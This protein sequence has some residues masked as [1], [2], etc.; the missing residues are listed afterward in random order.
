[1]TSLQ[2]EFINF[3]CR[4]YESTTI[5][6]RCS[7][8][9][10]KLEQ[11][12][13]VKTLLLSLFL[14]VPCTVIGQDRIADDIS[15]NRDVRPILSDK[16]FQCHG[17]DE[18]SRE[19]DLRFDQRDSA[20][21]AVEPGNADDS[22]MIARISDDDPDYRMPPPDSH[23]PLKDSEIAILK[24]W[25]NQGAAWDKF[26][27]YEP[28][29]WHPVPDSRER[30]VNDHWIDKMIH[31]RLDSKGIKPSPRADK[32]TL[33][34]RV[35]F[36]LIG[37]PPTPQQVDLFVNDPSPTAYVNLVDRLLESKHF[38]ERIAMYWLDLVRFADTVG[39]HGDQDHN[40]SPYRD[41]VINAFNDNMPFDQFTREQLAGDLV[42]DSSREQKIASGYN[43]LLQT[44]HEGGLQPKEYRAIYAADR[45]RNVSA[46]WMGATIGC[47]QC[48]D[49]KYDPY[50]AKDFYALSAFFADI[51]DEQHFKDGSNAIPTRRSPEILLL[52]DSDQKE[53]DA[54]RRRIGLAKREL[55]KLKKELKKLGAIPEPNPKTSERD[56]RVDN[57]A[58]EPPSETDDKHDAR[59]AKLASFISGETSE[60]K[61]LESEL[62]R[63]ESRGSWTMI[64]RALK[65]PRTVR[66]LPRGNWL[67]E[68]GP[69]VKPAIPEFLGTIKTQSARPTRLDLANWLTD[70]ESGTGKLTS[71]V[72]VN[73]IWYL[74]MGVGISKSLDDFGGQ[75]ETPAFPE[76]LDNLAID[77]AKD[78][79][80]KRLI[81]GVVTSQTYQQSSMASDALRE[82]DPY[83]QLF[84]RQS[85]FR[86]PAEMIR[87][88]SLAIS[89]LL[90]VEKIGGKS[91]KPYQPAKY[92][93]HLN[94]PKRKY[95][96][97]RNK[98]QWRRGVYVHWQRMFLHP[99]LKAL[100]APSRE[101]CT[102]ERPRSNTPLAALAMMNDPCFVEAAR[103][104][105]EKIVD[106][107]E[108]D[109]FAT[110]LDFAFRCAV[111][112]RP[113]SSE[114][115]VLSE[116]YET[117]YQEYVADKESAK[118]ILGIGQAPVSKK[119][120]PEQLAAW[121]T[122]ARAILN[123]SETISRN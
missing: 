103:Q 18:S 98:T 123:M 99:S 51:D 8:R 88:S 101:E 84:A 37:L 13:S 14:I 105:A 63:I 23:K 74:L 60:I 73:R 36:D 116:L 90:N 69:V 6:A 19:V 82:M 3:T 45:V 106:S 55:K 28:P 25:I 112:R 21:N 31:S 41:Y 89:G 43:R 121:T 119:I 83:N 65:S 16:C 40:I 86:L 5:E 102:C 87:D 72:F 95:A 46:V 85:R 79:N 49:H 67:D 110:R 57:D 94:F 38:G 54:T 4:P 93:Q 9:L 64:T 50:T 100:D 58:D 53:L 44:T 78:W 114:Q 71:R 70:T 26:W 120:P 76:L 27:A 91:V 35:Y 29:T 39:Y 33:I 92:Y 10:T 108:R 17:P 113:N 15:F 62:A 80:I 75:G 66:V 11:E 30:N 34:R 115:A 104:F 56:I 97:T 24:A 68:T 122:V 96:H 61:Q 12:L 59:V 2:S 20:M 42:P 52:S 111:S 32:I 48:H 118:Q 109:D 117:S 107:V 22:E 81:R 7:F 77:F 1:M 47:A